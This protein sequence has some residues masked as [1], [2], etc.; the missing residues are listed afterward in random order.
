MYSYNILFS[1]CINDTSHDNIPTKPFWV[2]HL[3]L[4]VEG[5]G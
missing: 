4:A 2:A 3:L 5:P 1:I